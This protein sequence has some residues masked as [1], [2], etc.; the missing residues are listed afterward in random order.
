MIKSLIL[1]SIFSATQY[2]HD[3]LL[4]DLMRYLFG[5]CHSK[6]K[7]HQPKPWSFSTRFETGLLR[8]QGP[9]KRA[10]YDGAQTLGQD[11]LD[12]KCPYFLAV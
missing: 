8:Y 4:A 5:L 9:G 2:F 1:S 11:H 10:E 7:G 12:I 6:D 3:L